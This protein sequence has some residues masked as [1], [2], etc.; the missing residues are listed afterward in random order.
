MAGG[1]GGAPGPNPSSLES[2]DHY[3]AGIKP[4]S[5]RITY[6]ESKLSDYVEIKRSNGSLCIEL[7]P[8]LFDI[9]RKAGK[10]NN[11]KNELKKGLGL[12]GIS[13]IITYFNETILEYAGK[14]LPVGLLP[15]TAGIGA[16]AYVLKIL[17]DKNKLILGYI[18]HASID[19]IPQWM[20]LVDEAQETQGIAV[21]GN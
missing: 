14:V 15:K 8:P 5:L 2:H 6:T 18:H 1:N 20:G 7:G 12:I 21:D 16:A 3:P 11:L 19:E 13:G 9:V 10:L 17:W 4:I